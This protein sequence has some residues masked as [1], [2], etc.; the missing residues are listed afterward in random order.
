MS[1]V[2]LDLVKKSMLKHQTRKRWWQIKQVYKSFRD[3][4]GWS[5]WDCIRGILDWW[6]RLFPLSNWGRMART[7][8]R[9]ER[10]IAN[11]EL[12]DIKKLFDLK[13]PLY[14][15]AKELGKV[16]AWISVDEELPE[17]G[18]QVFMIDAETGYAY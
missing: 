2:I 12:D 13:C 11:N 17:L 5:K 4:D 8:S 15:L 3:I 14:S 9:L 7:L 10:D 1:E 18:K 6:W 16:E